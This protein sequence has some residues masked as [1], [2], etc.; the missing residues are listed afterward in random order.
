MRTIIL[1][2][3][4][5]DVLVMLG[6]ILTRSGHHVIPKFDAESALSVIREGNRIDLVITDYQMPG[7]DGSEFM[8]KLRH[9]SPS[10]PVIVL[11]AHGSVD[12]Y[13][14]SMSL[15]AFEYITKPVRTSELERIVM[16]ALVRSETNDSL[17]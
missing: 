1:I 10:V 17:S 6:E 9:L 14:K 8:L 3:D 15:G 16:A 2:D 11:T 12:I 4:D 5:P 7:M 13:I